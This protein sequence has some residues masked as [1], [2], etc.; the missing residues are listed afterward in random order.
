MI[1]HG[2]SGVIQPV[3]KT[4]DVKV[5]CSVDGATRCSCRVPGPDHRARQHETQSLL[6]QE[7]DAIRRRRKLYLIR[8]AKDLHVAAELLTP[9]LV[10]LM[11]HQYALVKQVC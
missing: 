5:L 10:E 8:L 7:N 2:E 9:I 6:N 11:I 1:R 3:S 4:R